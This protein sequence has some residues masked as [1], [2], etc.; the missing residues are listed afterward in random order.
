M[1]MAYCAYCGA[2]VREATYAPCPHCGRAAN[3]A[4][5]A[6]RPI[7]PA[8]SS[9]A[10][11]VVLVVVGVFVVIGIIGI[12]A[13]IA[14]PNMLT[15]MQ[16]SRQKRSM[17]DMRSLSLA[18]DSYKIDHNGALPSGDA[19]SLPSQ[20][21]PTYIKTVPVQDGWAHPLHYA[22]SESGQEQHYLL[23]SAG[24]D[25]ALE[26]D[27]LFAYPHA[28]TSNFDCDIVYGDGEFVQYPETVQH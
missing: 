25:G 26:R 3:G 2:Q 11:T 23:A 14:I 9:G 5:Q 17:A 21:S 4:P 10:S 8:A 1:N 18:I 6:A 20:L 22:H 7:A 12:L 27:D 28:S 13:A 16:R 15:A 24:K 19:A